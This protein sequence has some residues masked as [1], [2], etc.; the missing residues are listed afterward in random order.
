MQ[1][2]MSIITSALGSADCSGSRVD[3]AVMATKIITAT[4]IF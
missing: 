3:T 1:R 2:I 4:V